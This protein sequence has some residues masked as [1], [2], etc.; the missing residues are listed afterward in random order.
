MPG[1]STSR[2]AVNAGLVTVEPSARVAAA[3]GKFG[4]IG[5]G[6]AARLALRRHSGE[7]E[8]DAQNHG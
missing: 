6:T 7:S 1:S 3:D 2:E 4:K 5:D 8:G